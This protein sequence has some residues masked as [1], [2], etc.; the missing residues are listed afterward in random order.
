[1]RPTQLAGIEVNPYAQQLASVVV[2]IGYLE[3][4]HHNG[5][6]AP[7]DPV[8]ERM[9][10]IRHAD[11]VLDLSDP[12][13]P[14]EPEWPAAEVIVGNPPFLGGKKMRAELGD[15]YVEDLFRLW[16]ERVPPEADLCCYWFEKARRLV[17]T[18]RCK[19]AGLLAT[20]GI[21]GGANRA[22]LKRIKETGDIFFA[23]SD[24][25]WVLDG[26]NVHV[27]MVGFDD[28][29]ETARRLDGK[30]VAAINANLSSAADVTQARRLEDNAD[31]AYMGDTKGGSF[32]IEEAAALE[33]L[34][35][36]NPN[37]L[38]TSNVLVPWVNGLDVTRRSR[39]FWII[40]FGVGTGLE[41]ASLYDAAFCRAKERVFDARSASRSTIESWWLHE[42][43]RVEMRKALAP[44]PRFLA[45]T[46]VSKHRLFVWMS[47]PT[48]PD[49]QLIAFAH[50]DDYFFGVLHSRPHE[51]WGL[52]L[53]TRLESRPRYT[54]T[55][56]FETFP[57]PP[58]TD[59]QKAA[60]TTAAREL[61]TLRNN[62]L[63]PPEWTRQEVLE[64]PGSAGG[65]WGPYLHDADGR[66]IGT[67]RYPRTV[68]KDE[69]C[70]RK[71]KER[72]L[73]NLYNQ[74][75]TWLD[76]AHRKLD[77]AVFAAYGWDPDISDENLL[78]A[79]LAL[80]QHEAAG[81][82]PEERD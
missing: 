80:N 41:Q 9:E 66:G 37:G 1:V 12:A 47:A 25:D 74:R 5:F 68:P 34:R 31:L 59:E 18:G 29:I 4:M 13:G 60:I 39:M 15:D 24:R 64:F 65:P 81:Q 7:T 70:A 56:C 26:A 17:E 45:T 38:P 36:P 22:V 69:E 57:F 27:S 49:H 33:L 28:G 8:L 76:L 20:Q 73:T 23:E 43:P 3:W 62:W 54:P 79:L 16:R 72:T 55:T 42:R 71:L 78:A 32:E 52:T 63:N 10:T 75:P 2:W 44:L 53:G 61:D 19:R 21:R 35:T 77:T 50:S 46:T 51:V 48:L 30:A 11:A 6:I 82:R 14:R 58:A 40:D 67:V